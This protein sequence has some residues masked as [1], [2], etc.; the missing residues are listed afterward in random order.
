MNL[1]ENSILNLLSNKIHFKYTA[2]LGVNVIME[3]DVPC[4]TLRDTV[5]CSFSV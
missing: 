3:T 1:K 5:Q 2:G 4:E